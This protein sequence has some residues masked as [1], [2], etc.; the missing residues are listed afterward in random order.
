MHLSLPVYRERYL[1]MM[2]VLPLL[3]L[4]VPVSAAVAVLQLTAEVHTRQQT[5]ELYS[6]CEEMKKRR[7]KKTMMRLQEEQEARQERDFDSGEGRHLYEDDGCPC[8]HLHLFLSS[9]QHAKER[10]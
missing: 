4:V 9:L 3:G 5:E 1:K 10:R 7:K 8:H 6:D 2:K